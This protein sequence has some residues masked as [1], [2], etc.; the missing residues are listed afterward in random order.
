M[1]G[2]RQ[3]APGSEPGGGGAH[4]VRIR[5]DR[6]D[7]WP[8][9][10]M[11][12]LLNHDPKE[13]SE[14]DALP[15]GWHWLYFRT[16]FRL[17]QLDVDGHEARGGFM[18]ATGLPRRMWAGGALHE[19]SPLI[20]GAEAEMRSRVRTVQERQGKSGRLVFVTVAHEVHQG[21]RLCIE[22]DQVV[23]YREAG[24]RSARGGSG[25]VSGGEAKPLP[26]A[27]NPPPWRME[28]VP[29]T[30]ALF[31]FSALT[32]NSH[33]IHYDYP[34]VTKRE[35][36][37]GLLVHG[38]LTALLLMDAARCQY[39]DPVVQFRYRALVPLLADEPIVLVGRGT[40]DD[41]GRGRNDRNPAHTEDDATHTPGASGA[42]IVEAIGPRG[43]AM[44][45]RVVLGKR[46]PPR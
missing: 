35:G 38:P 16:V 11:L 27:A 22:E 20:I 39:S 17:A 10:A 40:S 26:L 14:G 45:G 4:R 43:V 34:Y 37:P 3:S 29:T 2:R 41:M 28:F 25:K 24:D 46:P 23:V 30:V 32:W 19:R 5:Q 9:S 6:I 21:G 12:G 15:L 36:Y 44:R 42:E 18:P 1:N 13:L 8:A 31:Q 7:L 33:R